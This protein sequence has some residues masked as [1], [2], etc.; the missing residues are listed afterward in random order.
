MK[1]IFENRP[2]LFWIFHTSGWI[3]LALM[4]GIIQLFKFTY[5]FRSTFLYFLTYFIGFCLTLGLRYFYRYIYS[6]TKSVVSIL[7]IIIISSLIANT[8]WEPIDVLVSQFFWTPEELAEQLKRIRSLTLYEYYKSNLIWF[9]FIMVWSTLYFGLINWFDQ[10]EQRIKTEQAMRLANQAQLRML[11][12]QINPHFLFN[13]LNSIK[14]LTYENPDQAV[15]ML[16]ELSEFLRS[17]LRFCDSIYIP[18]REEIE[19]IEKYLSIEKI[20]FE[21]RLNYEINYDFRVMESE[22]LCFITQPL[23]ENAIKHGLSASPEGIELKIDFSE[24]GDNLAIEI[25]NT[26]NYQKETESDGMGLKNITERLDNAY[27]DRYVFRIYDE[28]G[29]VKA[30]LLIPGGK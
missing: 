2:R 4:M 18:V 27:G 20:R 9:M 6:R 28:S 22:I 26:G 25:T 8:I 1:D 17:T 12:Y 11:R 23:I 13:S 10:A 5:S 15:L 21:E 3:L 29:R 30:R 19:M 16:T 7:F 24:S 14:A